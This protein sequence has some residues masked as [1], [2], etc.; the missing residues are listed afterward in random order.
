MA[1]KKKEETPKPPKESTQLAPL[2]LPYFDEVKDRFGVTKAEWRVLTEAIFPSAETTEGV[3]LALAYCKKLGYDVFK[4]PVNIVPIWNKKL[5]KNVEGVWPGIGAF[6]ITAARTKGYAG[7]DAAVFGPTTKRSFTGDVKVWDGGGGSH[8]ERKTSEVEF[9][10]WCQVTVYRV[11]DGVRCPFVGPR[12]VWLETY[13]TLGYNNELPN[14]MWSDRPFG[15]CEKCAEAAALR[16]AFPEE[17]GNEHTDDEMRRGFRDAIEVEAKEVPAGPK[18]EDVA[19]D[20]AAEL[21]AKQKKEPQN[22]Q[23]PAKA[24]PDE[25]QTG[26]LFD[27]PPPFKP[28]GPLSTPEQARMIGQILT[29]EKIEPIVFEAW[30]LK[31]FGTRRIDHLTQEQADTVPDRIGMEIDNLNTNGAE[32]DIPRGDDDR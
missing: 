2:R 7:C 14:G 26:S 19:A 17:L 18:P 27:Q 28:K 5:G 29:K 3:I 1:E 4:H 13:G 23:E 16:K 11:I 10:E 8:H 6:R 15:Q 22:T 31:W 25:R 20:M 9:P 12:V 24:P 21:K 30:L 32:D